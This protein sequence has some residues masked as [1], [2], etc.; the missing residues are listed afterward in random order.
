MLSEAENGLADIDDAGAAMMRLVGFG[1]KNHGRTLA[2]V[3]RSFSEGTGYVDLESDEFDAE[4]HILG[5]LQERLMTLRP[6]SNL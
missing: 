6:K 1:E 4:G 2:I 3:P 5:R